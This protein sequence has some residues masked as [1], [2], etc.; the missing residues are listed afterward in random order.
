MYLNPPYR[1]KFFKPSSKF[2][3]IYF[4]IAILLG[5]A[6]V[7]GLLIFL[8]LITILVSLKLVWRIN[9][10]PILAFVIFY[11]WIQISMKIF[12]ANLLGLPIQDIAFSNSSEQAIYL[13]LLGLLS[14]S[15]GVH[16]VLRK[17]KP[18]DFS[19]IVTLAKRYSLR[20]L[21]NVYIVFFLIYIFLKGILFVVPGLSQIIVGFLS[22]KIVLIYFIFLV[23]LI[24]KRYKILIWVVLAETIF[25]MSG[26]FS[27]FKLPYMLLFLA[28]FTINHK[29][30]LRGL[31]FITPIFAMVII[32][33]LTWTAIKTDYRHA[34]NKGEKTQ[35][36]T[37]DLSEQI[38]ILFDNINQ[39]D[40][41]KFG[42]A[43]NALA[44]RLAY[45]DIFGEVIDYVPRNRDYEYGQLWLGSIKHVLMPRILFPDKPRLDDSL[46]TRKYTGHNY[47][48]L[49]EGTSIGIGYFGESYIDFG[50]Y[51]MY[52]PL[53]IM[54][55]FYGFIYR[56]LM[57]N[58]KNTLLAYSMITA[59]LLVAYPFEIRNDKLFGGVLIAFI[60]LLIMKK[61][62]MS[63]LFVSTY[64][65]KKGIR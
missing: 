14:I 53:F 47:A 6:S 51:F 13:S 32:M 24:Q 3:L 27:T 17:L 62:F 48:A 36:I 18:I 65:L 7:N 40:M 54:G 23:S 49:D 58:V 8:A 33:G 2:S 29:V 20:K 43:A 52:F 4:L 55:L 1:K 39:I 61:L 42:I 38:Q 25:G 46:R 50:P 26:F 11:H 12:H 9:E 63:K 37:V 35:V 30:S 19:N 28:Y 15:L 10:P 34:I 16:L 64:V 59:I 22:F 45:V 41:N 60:M 21:F 56:Y 57:K 5:L 31:K 44:Y